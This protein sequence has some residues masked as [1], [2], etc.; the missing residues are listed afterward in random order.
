MFTPLNRNL[1]TLTIL[2]IPF[3]TISRVDVNLREND[4]FRHPVFTFLDDMK[5]IDYSETIA[6]FADIIFGSV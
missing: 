6:E 3:H 1:S 2:K 5:T 4:T